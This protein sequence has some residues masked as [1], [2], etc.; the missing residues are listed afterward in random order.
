MASVIVGVVNGSV[1]SGHG[2]CVLKSRKC[3]SNTQEALMHRVAIELELP[4]D[5][6]RFRLPP[7]LNARLQQLL[8]RQNSGTA[9]DADER[10]EAEGLVE[11][12][13]LL[14]LLR[15]RAESAAPGSIA[16]K[17]R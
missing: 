6:A 13:E 17:R 9:L 11:V 1:V 7:A 15:L 16:T 10:Q 12:A 8:D 2:S 5:L 4:G 14:T 3:F